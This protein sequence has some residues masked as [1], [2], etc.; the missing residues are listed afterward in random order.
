MNVWMHNNDYYVATGSTEM[1]FIASYRLFHFTFALSR[2]LMLAGASIFSTNYC[3]YNFNLERIHD[4][5]FSTGN[6][7][8][9]VVISFPLPG[10]EPNGH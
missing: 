7:W 10:T 1:N 2:L 4:K 3:Y 9:R 8:E 5:K 6:E